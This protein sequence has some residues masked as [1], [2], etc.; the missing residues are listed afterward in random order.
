[1]FQLVVDNKLKVETT[2]MNLKDIG[3][4]WDMEVPDGVRLVIIQGP[5]NKSKRLIFNI[6]KSLTNYSKGKNCWTRS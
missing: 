2:R 5:F 3:T 6:L 1:M 4:L